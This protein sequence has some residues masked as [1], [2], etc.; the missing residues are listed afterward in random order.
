MAA[1]ERLAVEGASVDAKT[2]DGF[3]DPAVVLAASCGHA[4]A[5]SALGRLGG[6]LDATNPGGWTALMS[7]ANGRAGAAAALLEGGAAVDAVNSDGE[8]ALILA[9]YHGEAECARLLLEAGADR[10]LRDSE[11][12]TALEWAEEKGKEEKKSW[13]DDED[14]VARQKGRAEVAALLRE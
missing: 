8:T 10:T 12:K 7:A 6:D 2:E 1:I 13:E 3:R 4:E 11:G 9:A 14:F 5:V